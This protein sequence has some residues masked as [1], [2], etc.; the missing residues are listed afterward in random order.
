MGEADSSEGKTLAVDP[1]ADAAGADDSSRTVGP[2]TTGSGPAD[3]TREG[4]DRD[5]PTIAV[6]SSGDS[7]PDPSDPLGFVV[8]DDRTIAAAPSPPGGDCGGVGLERDATVPPPA[9]PSSAETIAKAD[10]PAPAAP[11]ERPLPAIAGYEILGELGR[12]GMGVVYRAR[13]V[14]LNRPCALKM[15]LGGA[16]ADAPAA[17]RFL[18]EAEAVARLQHPNVVQIHHVGEADGLPYFELE[19]VDGGSLEKALDGTPWHERRAAELVEALARG[20]AEAHRL[21]IIHRD[22]KPANV[23][24]A[25]DGTPKIGDFGL[26]KSLANDS[27]LTATDSIMGSPGYM[28]P[29]QAEGKTKQVGPAADVYALGAIL[30]ELLTGRPPFVGASI[31]ETLE[32]VRLTEPVAPSR[33]VPRLPRD[34]ETIALKCLQKEP[35]KRYDSAADLAADLRR[36]LD[37]E[38]ILARPVGPAERA[39][40]W[41]RRKPVL[42]GLAAALAASLVA[43]FTGVAWQW[44]RA[45]AKAAE[46]RT[47]AGLAEAESRRADAAA[48]QAGAEADRAR[49]QTALTSF[50]QG[51]SRAEQGDVAEGMLWMVEALERTPESHPEFRALLRANLPAWETSLV[52]LESAIP[53][54]DGTLLYGL[55]PDGKTALTQL[56]D[57]V[58]LRARDAATGRPIG[59]A[60][61]HESLTT[62]V[63]SPDGRTMATGGQDHTARLWEVATGRPIG[64]PMH[65]QQ[66]VASVAFSPDGRRVVTGSHDR[67]ARLWDAETGRPLGPPMAHEGPVYVAR[68]SPDGRMIATG[69]LGLGAQRWDARSG[70]P[71]GP[72]MRHRWA[73][74]AVEFSPDGALLLTGSGQGEGAAQLWEAATGRPLG[75]PVPHQG[76]VCYVGFSPDGTVG[77]TVGADDQ[78]LRL[79]DVA[80]GR[81][82]GPPVRLLGAFPFFLPEGR[83]LVVNDSDRAISRVLALGAGD[84]SSRPTDRD[85][86]I[87]SP[88]TSS[89]APT[90]LRYAYAAFSPDGTKLLTQGMPRARVWDVATGR[91]VG[92]AIPQRWAGAGPVAFSPDGTKFATASDNLPAGTWD[93][94]IQLSDAKTGGPLAPPIHPIDTVKALAFSPDGSLLATGDFSDGVQLWDASTGAPVGPRLIQANLVL[95]LAFSPDGKRLA[96]GTTNDRGKNN[97]QVRLWDLATHQPIGEPMRHRDSGST[98]VVAFSPDGETL[99]SVSHDGLAWRWDARTTRP[100]GRPIRHPTGFLGAVFRRDGRAVLTGTRDGTARL[101]DLR[102]GEPLSP[103]VNRPSAATALA[104]RPDGAAFAAGYAD[105]MTRLWDLATGRPIGPPLVHRGPVLAVAFS[106]DGRTLLSVDNTADIRTWTVPPPANE[107]TSRLLRRVQALTGMELDPGQSIVSLDREAWRGR[108][109]EVEERSTPTRPMGDE[110]DARSWHEARA[111]AAEESGMAFAAL[112]HLDRLIAARPDDGAL[113][114]RRALVQADAGRFEAAEEEL[115]RALKLGPLNP[116]VDVL[117]HRADAAGASGRWELALWALDHALAARPGDWGL[118]VDRAAALDHLGRSAERDVALDRAIEHGAD[119]LYLARKAREAEAAGDR[120][121]ASTLRDLA[122]ERLEARPSCHL[123]LELAADQ[124]RRDQPQKA[125]DL[126]DRLL[127][128]GEAARPDQRDDALLWLHLGRPDRYRATCA[129]LLASAGDAPSPLT[130]LALA[131]EC[132][133]GPEAVADPKAVIRLAESALGGVRADQRPRALRILGAALYRAGRPAE[134]VARLEESIQ[135]GDGQGLPQDWAFLAMAHQAQGDPEAARRWLRKVADRLPP[136]YWEGVEL[137][138]LQREAESLILGGR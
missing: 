21:G 24:L 27:G 31:L 120:A 20:V 119:S 127:R 63:L 3:A 43:G 61:T 76:I 104:I 57:G 91:P 48:Q 109:Q 99:L 15:I 62:A 73:V 4:R 103:P 74:Y 46:A 14:R 55:S 13:Q 51:W 94:M 77:L 118:D 11:R 49:F 30:Y 16:H 101:W 83:S 100:I 44:R 124:L 60:M 64:D 35:A 72:P 25:A 112:W 111:R 42:A 108:L 92:A 67:T 78:R 79:W 96:V 12:G 89:A 9:D 105:G 38:P 71:L 90:P 135:V 18:A 138:V 65:H 125:A 52:R 7:T 53:S 59:R 93:C 114:A 126:L 34:I 29:E 47:K 115:A 40:R 128:R 80:T 23:L 68:F 36:F 66:I 28:A 122:I 136:T 134:S 117:A 37:G 41:C 133:L 123:L 121:R 22:L 98:G 8:Q 129:K 32:Q 85:A 6:A 54:E 33:L 58:S 19:Y 1:T 116:C 106:P 86:G 107:S 50:V 97:S 81:L 88:Q 17:V 87:R 84:L 113:L 102:T 70:Q 5:R 137:K 110:A 82:L 39:W 132:V 130:A 69:S 10:R 2:G 75:P 56:R 131:W 45:E 95:A 26:A